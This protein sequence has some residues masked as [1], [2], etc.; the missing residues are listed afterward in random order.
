MIHRDSRRRGIVQVKTGNTPVDLDELDKAAR[1]DGT[2]S[3]AYASCGIYTGN[4]SA[5]K[6]TNEELL[7]FVQDNPDLMPARV[8]MWF[9]LAK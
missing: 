5:Q 8:R 7:A 6:I 3:F 4:G 9:D 2:D 1:D